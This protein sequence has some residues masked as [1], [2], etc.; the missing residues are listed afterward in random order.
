MSALGSH[1]SATGFA[2][3]NSCG[4]EERTVAVSTVEM[5]VIL[6]SVDCSLVFVSDSEIFFAFNALNISEIDAYISKA[7]SGAAVAS[8]ELMLYL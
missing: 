3:A 4:F 8:H 1:V 6:A 2:S 5:S 7:L